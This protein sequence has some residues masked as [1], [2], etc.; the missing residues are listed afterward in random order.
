MNTALKVTPQELKNTASSFED[1]GRNVNTTT[2][3]MLTLVN[4]ITGAVWS[5]EAATAYKTK[6][7]DLADD[8][9]KLNSMIAEHVADLR[10]I[11]DTYIKAED[12]NKELANTLASDI[13]S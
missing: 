6:F 1:T 10:D 12:A 13:I 5:G 4:E 7:A 3:A 2:Q 8:I 11:A 9:S